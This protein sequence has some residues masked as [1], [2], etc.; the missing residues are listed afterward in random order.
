MPPFH[1]AE[2]ANHTHTDLF[3]RDDFARNVAAKVTA[4][5]GAHAAARRAREER[6]AAVSVE[7]ARL[8]AKVRPTAL[9]VR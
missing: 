6:D 1:A 8:E 2:R 5:D 3:C 4:I 9:E 7:C